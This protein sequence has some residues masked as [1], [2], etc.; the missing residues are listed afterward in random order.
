[1]AHLSNAICHRRRRHGWSNR[2]PQVHRWG[3][4]TGN[5]RRGGVQMPPAQP[6]VPQAREKKKS[7][8]GSATGGI[9]P[10]SGPRKNRGSGLRDGKGTKRR[11][12]HGGGCSRLLF[13]PWLQCPVW[14]SSFLAPVGS[15]EVLVYL[16]RDGPP[17]RP[18][19]ASRPSF[20]SSARPLLSCQA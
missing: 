12:W 7:G 13:V 18:C 15:R 4:R 1:M 14:S 10:G 19:I 17:S 11:T 8:R 9:D 16:F 20:P 5:Y 6:R 2:S 3:R